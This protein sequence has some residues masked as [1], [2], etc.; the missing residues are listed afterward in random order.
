MRALYIHAREF[1]Y[2]PIEKARISKVEEASEQGK[3]FE[4]LLV[5]YVTIEK[6][7]FERRREILDKM[8]GDIKTQLERLNLNRLVI[9]PYAHLSDNLEE[10]VKAVRLLK[11]LDKKI[12]SG[13]SGVEYDRAPF[14]WY[15]EFRIHCPGH[16][17]SEL[18]RSF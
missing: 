14:G 4:N 2:K 15:K 6:G 12:K 17:L 8:L 13:L 1:Y 11:L 7:D 18:S 16:P 9:Y 10:P 3:G 5:V